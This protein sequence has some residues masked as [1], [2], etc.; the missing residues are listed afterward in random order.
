MLGKQCF[1]EMFAIFRKTQKCPINSDESDE[2]I[3][4]EFLR[5]EVLCLRKRGEVVLAE[6]PIN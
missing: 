1:D 4:D 5:F 3:S 6:S 2:S